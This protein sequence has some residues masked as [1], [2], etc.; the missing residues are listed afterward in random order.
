MNV[1]NYTDPETSSVGLHQR[2][3]AE[4]LK[5][6][7]SERRNKSCNRAMRSEPKAATQN[8]GP[9]PLNRR[10]FANLDST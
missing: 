1:R 5:K 7:T 6:L 9:F 2:N 4:A 8:H 10:Y 3:S